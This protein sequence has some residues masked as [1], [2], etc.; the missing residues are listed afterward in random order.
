MTT[1]NSEFLERLRRRKR[2]LLKEL[3]EVEARIR[4]LDS[5]TDD[6]PPDD[7]PD[8]HELGIHG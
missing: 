1:G 7:F 2:E 5:P 8:P 4:E 3:E 6:E